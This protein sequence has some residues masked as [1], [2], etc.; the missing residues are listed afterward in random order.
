M[1]DEVL[2]TYQS[3]VIRKEGEEDEFQIPPNL[4]CIFGSESKTYNDF[5]SF[6]VKNKFDFSVRNGLFFA[7][8]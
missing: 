2:K 6:D 7:R 5:F 4:K 3:Y 8:G 1:I